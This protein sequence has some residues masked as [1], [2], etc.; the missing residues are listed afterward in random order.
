MYMLTQM[1]QEVR[2]GIM[3]ILKQSHPITAKYHEVDL[4]EYNVFCST[5]NQLIDDFNIKPN[6]LGEGPMVTVVRD[7]KGKGFRS[8]KGS[9]D[10]IQAVD[11][12]LHS[13]EIDLY[14][15]TM[16]RCDVDEVLDQMEMFDVDQPFKYLIDGF[17]DEGW[18]NRLVK[19]SQNPENVSFLI[20]LMFM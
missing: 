15:D 13:Q 8:F 19:T 17:G 16:P 7:G 12:Y 4:S 1:N 11:N 20:W 6:L 10:L 18:D 9:G 2:G 5:F 3:N 14:A